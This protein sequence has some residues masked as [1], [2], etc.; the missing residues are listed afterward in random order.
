MFNCCGLH[1]PPAESNTLMI[2]LQRHCAGDAE[3]FA[4]VAPGKQWT[5]DCFASHPWR[6]VDAT[7]GSILQEYVAVAGPQVVRVRPADLPPSSDLYSTPDSDNHESGS[8]AVADAPGSAT[9]LAEADDFGFDG[10]GG[11]E[12]HY[13]TA[14]VIQHQCHP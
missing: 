9:T 10:I 7:D 5:V 1:C 6:F 14:K 12:N 13:V 3:F 2:A 4:Q 11:D 8:D